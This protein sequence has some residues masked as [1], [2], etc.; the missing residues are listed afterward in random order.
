MHVQEKEVKNV[1]KMAIFPHFLQATLHPDADVV[2]VFL[3]LPLTALF[4]QED[5]M[6]GRRVRWQQPLQPLWQALKTILALMSQQALLHVFQE[7][8]Q[9]A[10]CVL[11]FAYD[12]SSVSWP[13][14]GCLKTMLQ[15]LNHTVRL[16]ISCG[17]KS[18]EALLPG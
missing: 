13:A 5:L 12:G 17:C 14:L 16:G 1:P 6:Q 7:N 10:P 2:A 18:H 8:P 15:T 11:D 3:T 9:L 4:M